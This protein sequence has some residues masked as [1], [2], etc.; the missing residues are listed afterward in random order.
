MRLV[1]SLAALLLGAATPSI[2]DQA[3][4]RVLV[5]GQTAARSFAYGSEPRQ[6][7]ELFTR[8]KERAPLIVYI[9]GGGWSAG[10]PKSGARG[11]QADHFTA[12]GYAYATAGYRFVPDVTVEQQLGDIAVAVAL[13]RRQQGVDP[14]RIVLI[15]H[16]SGAHLAALIGTD[17]R[18][19]RSARVPFEALR[20][21][22][23]LDPAV[24]NV[25]PAMAATGNPTIDRYFRPAFG[26]DPARQSALSP[27]V[28]AEAP[29]APYWLSLYDSGNLFSATQSADLSA[30]LI[31]AGAKAASFA[32]VSGTTHMRLNNEIGAPGDRATGLIDAFLARAMPE[33]RRPRFR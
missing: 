33:S 13:L 6:T 9:H 4:P 26:D 31:G 10:S 15:G 19:L 8:G 23:L 5:V 21:V 11:A 24:L 29:N 2:A 27:L 22:V 1:P 7:V 17:P 20:G 28:H 14:G 32:A 12:A 25:P 16:S 3:G 30:A 18:Y